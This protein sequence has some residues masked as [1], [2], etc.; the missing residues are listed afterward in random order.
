MM[1]AL[2]PRARVLLVGLLAA[3]IAAPL[4]ADRYLMSVLILIFYFTM[5]GRPGT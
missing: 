2:N 1:E 4:V 3:V 5:W